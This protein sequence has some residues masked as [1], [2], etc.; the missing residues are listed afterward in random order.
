MTAGG[1][2]ARLFLLS[3]AHCGG[4]RAELLMSERA[5]FPLADRLR[6][7]DPVTLG[8]AFAFL[9]G[10][11]FAGKLAYAERFARTPAGMPA[12]ASGALVITTNR[13]L[14][15]VGSPITLADLRD[16]GAVSIRTDDPRYRSPVTRDAAALARLDADVI[17]L[18]SV[19]TGK[20]VDVLLDS[21]GERLLFPTVF[22]GRGDMSRGSLLL[23]AVR[24]GAELAYEPVATAVRSR[25]RARTLR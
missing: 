22:V 19:A 12:G 10:L 5:R 15:P 7:G 18:G 16:F 1:R 23:R 4:K 14:V 25:A 24:E 6:R 8:E 11:Y 3:P 2:S 21:F 9:S 17:L 20:Y 13:G